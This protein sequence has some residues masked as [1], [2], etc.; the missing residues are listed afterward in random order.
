[1]KVIKYWMNKGTDGKFAI[2]Y[3]RGCVELGGN[4]KTESIMLE[5]MQRVFGIKSPQRIERHK[6]SRV[7]LVARVPYPRFVDGISYLM[8]NYR[9]EQT[10]SFGRFLG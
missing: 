7:I 6:G 3:R 2:K 4:R 10:R 8:N 1:M 9:V 5:N